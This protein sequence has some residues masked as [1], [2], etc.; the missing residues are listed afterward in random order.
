M[1]VPNESE[2]SGSTPLFASSSLQVDTSAAIERTLA[3]G[4][5]VAARSGMAVDANHQDLYADYQYPRL[6]QSCGHG[7]FVQDLLRKVVIL[8]SQ[9]EP[10]NR[11]DCIYFLEIQV[12]GIGL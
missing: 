7:S 6:R 2:P 8:S 1:G 3:R 10:S 12:L 9:R 4:P 11:A 5:R